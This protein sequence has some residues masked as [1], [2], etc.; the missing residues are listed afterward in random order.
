MAMFFNDFG[1]QA[2]ASLTLGFSSDGNQAWITGG[3]AMAIFDIR[4]QK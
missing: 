2:G 4:T 1:S 3:A